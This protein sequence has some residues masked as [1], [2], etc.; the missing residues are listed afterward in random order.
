MILSQAAL[1]LTNLIAEL[2][3]PL[4][5]FLNSISEIRHTAVHR[6]PVTVDRIVQFATNAESLARLL[7]DEHCLDELGWIKRE[8]RLVSDNLKRNKDLL[9]AKLTEHT[10]ATTPENPRT[11]PR[12][13]HAIGL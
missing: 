6:L 11:W 4:D 7:Q 8:L 1:F 3:S 10:L 9:E 12:S 2:G 5:E 13:S